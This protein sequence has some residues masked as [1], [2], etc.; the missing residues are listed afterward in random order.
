[1]SVTSGRNS[2]GESAAI[3]AATTPVRAPA[4][5]RPII[6][7][8][9]TVPVPTAAR[10]IRCHSTLRKPSRAKS[11]TTNEC[12]GGYS[13]VGTTRWKRARSNGRM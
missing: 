13:A 9:A 12:N 1:M 3:T 4:T 10:P 6:P 7:I 8:T 2:I 11:E 5:R